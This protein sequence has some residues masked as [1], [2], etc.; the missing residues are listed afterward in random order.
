[1]NTDKINKLENNI[2]LKKKIL[3]KG[4]WKNYAIVPPSLVLFVGILGIVYLLN[5]DKLISLY[6]IPFILI[7]IIGTIWIKAVRRYIINKKISDNTTFLVCPAI[8]FKKEGKKK[9]ILFSIGRN[10]HNKYYLEKERKELLDNQTN[11]SFSG[12]QA[13]QI[14][15]SDIFMMELPVTEKILKKRHNS[16][17]EYLV[18]YTGSGAIDFL[19]PDDLKKYA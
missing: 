17:D 8:L 15:G 18:I 7:F 1:M 5:T 6:S 14:E 12:K 9:A 2:K 13:R 10:R 3:S 16:N 4:V 19:S 11:L